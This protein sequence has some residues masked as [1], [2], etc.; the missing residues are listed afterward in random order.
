MDISWGLMW[1]IFSLLWG[2]A[3][4][5]FIL[6]VCGRCQEVKKKKKIILG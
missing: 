3:K 6:V 5:H 2:C 1:T 4:L